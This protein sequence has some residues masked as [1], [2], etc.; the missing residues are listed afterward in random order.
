MNNL[1]LTSLAIAFGAMGFVASAHADHD[2][3]NQAYD[4]QADYYQNDNHQNYNNQYNNN[5]NY[6]GYI[7][8]GRY[9]QD[10]QYQKHN[11]GRYANAKVVRVVPI[12][13]RV[14]T[15]RELVCQPVNY[16]RY[17]NQGYGSYPSKPVINPGTVTGAVIGGV[18]GHQVADYPN[19][20]AGTIV[21]A[22]LGGLVGNSI[23]QNTNNQ[24]HA[25]GQPSHCYATPTRYVTQ[26]LGYDVTYRY[27]GGN[28]LVRMPYYP[29]KHLR[30]RID[31]AN[32]YSPQVAVRY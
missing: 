24:Y 25:N 1:T 22:T 28:Y 29:D 12:V 13:R 26:T 14:A 11:R 3:R 18:I 30:I 2:D 16:P 31:Q 27:Q 10:D 7:Q 17:Q 6:Y 21:G 19:K 15:S 32:Y 5:Q 8:N 4:N 20:A 9:Y 23:A